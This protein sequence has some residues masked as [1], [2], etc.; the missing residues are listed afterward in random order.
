MF[1]MFKEVTKS[2]AVVDL[3]PTQLLLD[4]E[5]GPRAAATKIFQ[6]VTIRACRF[7][8]TQNLVK[9]VRANRKLLSTFSKEDNESGKWL[10]AFLGPPCLPPYMVEEAFLEC[11]QRCC[12]HQIF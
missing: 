4:F 6:N 3:D 8:S 12:R 5:D 10:L 9:R 1:E 7:H 2:K 11:P